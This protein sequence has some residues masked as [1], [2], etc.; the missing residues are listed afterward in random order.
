MLTV[1]HLPCRIL[2]LSCHT[3]RLLLIV[4]LL[5]VLVLVWCRQIVV[6]LTLRL[7]PWVDILLGLLSIDVIRRSRLLILI[8]WIRRQILSRLN[9]SLVDRLVL[10]WMDFCILLRV[11]LGL[12]VSSCVHVIIVLSILR[13]VTLVI[14]ILSLVTVWVLF[15]DLLGWRGMW[16]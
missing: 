1:S 3:L 5:L 12:V 13:R 6:Y 14:M 10:L 2:I 11:M 9:L 4:S 15:I 7:F 8:N 16:I